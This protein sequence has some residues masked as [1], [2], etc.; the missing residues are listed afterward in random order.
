MSV[1]EAQLAAEKAKP[2][3]TPQRTQWQGKK[4]KP[5]EAPF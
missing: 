4:L 3:T 1:T 5:G 2:R